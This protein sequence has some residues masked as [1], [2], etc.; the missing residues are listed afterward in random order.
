VNIKRLLIA[1][2]VT[3]QIPFAYYLAG[4]DLLTRSQGLGA[5][6]LVS[7]YIFVITYCYLEFFNAKK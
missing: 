2:G 4:H 7:V 6:W 1:L 5:L 3:L